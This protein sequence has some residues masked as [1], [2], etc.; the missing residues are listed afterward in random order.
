MT[1]GMV[2]YGWLL[3]AILSSSL[4]LGWFFS[5]GRP[6]SW[7]IVALAL[8]GSFVYF[9]WPHLNSLDFNSRRGIAILMF[10]ALALSITA[11]VI[12]FFKRPVH[13]R[14]K[15]P[16]PEGRNPHL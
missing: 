14:E 16:F 10:L 13:T 7:T 2:L 6:H 12:P 8:S 9:V 4:G 5:T 1:Q 15:S 11:F 3:A